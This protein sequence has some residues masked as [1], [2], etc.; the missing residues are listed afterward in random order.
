MNTEI[1]RCG[2]AHL[3]SEIKKRRSNYIT[4]KYYE[5]SIT[6]RLFK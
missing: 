4:E 3:K 5:R 1:A 6:H 2:R